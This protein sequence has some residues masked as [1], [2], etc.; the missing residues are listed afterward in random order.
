MKGDKLLKIERF[1]K[2]SNLFL[3]K[4]DDKAIILKEDHNLSNDEI[5]SKFLTD[6]KPLSFQRNK[7]F[8]SQIINSIKAKPFELK[9]HFLSK[10]DIKNSQKASN[11]N[12]D[13]AVANHKQIKA[14]LSF[15]GGSFLEGF[16]E[17][18]GVKIDKALEKYEKDLLIIEEEDFELGTKESFIVKSTKG[19]IEKITPSIEN[20]KVARQELDYFYERHQTK[21]NKLNQNLELKQKEEKE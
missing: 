19:V 7:L 1:E 16:L 4:N 3:V 14:E 6:S 2:I 21:N 11:L 8:K 9:Q 12:N 18:F 13:N 15:Y 17:V 10:G 5:K 20:M